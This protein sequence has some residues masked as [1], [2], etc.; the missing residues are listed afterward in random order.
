[1]TF[2]FDKLTAKSQQAIAQAQ[3]RASELQNPHLEAIHVLEALGNVYFTYDS[4][5]CAKLFEWFWFKRLIFRPSIIK[6]Q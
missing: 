4:E 5:Y 2:Q 1:M 3:S 6:T